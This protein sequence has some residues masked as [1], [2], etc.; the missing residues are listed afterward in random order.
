[1]GSPENSGLSPAGEISAHQDQGLSCCRP[2]PPIQGAAIDA[3][4]MSGDQRRSPEKS[5]LARSP[6]ISGHPAPP[7]QPDEFY[8]VLVKPLA[9]RPIRRPV[10][11]CVALRDGPVSSKRLRCL[12]D[13]YRASGSPASRKPLI[14]RFIRRIPKVGGS[15]AYARCPCLGSLPDRRT[16]AQR[17]RNGSG[18]RVEHLCAG[19]AIVAI[20]VSVRSEACLIVV[21]KTLINPRLKHIH[22]RIEVGRKVASR[23]WICA[24]RGAALRRAG[25]TK[26]V[27]ERSQEAHE[28]YRL[29]AVGHGLNITAAYWFLALG[30]GIHPAKETLAAKSSATQPAR[31]RGSTPLVSLGI[32][33]T[34]SACAA[35]W[36]AT[37]VSGRG[38]SGTRP[39]ARA[40]SRG[41]SSPYRGE[42]AH[43]GLRIELCPFADT[44]PAAELAAAASER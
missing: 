33:A 22:G 23:V 29:A 10:Q 7:S 5:G 26:E 18:S 25:P 44:A 20:G 40:S 28:V 30:W 43:R 34:A 9:Q 42:E 1:M 24:V 2:T 36:T 13:V 16:F 38:R 17:T 15:D 11:N 3:S 41:L 8:D 31:V 32:E 39:A 27:L 6:E 37:A 35:G 4:P 19:V 12:W 14:S 21:R